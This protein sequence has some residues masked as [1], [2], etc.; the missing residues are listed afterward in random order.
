MISRE[1]ATQLLDSLNEERKILELG[2][3]RKTTTRVA[4]KRMTWR[5]DITNLSEGKPV[6]TALI[7]LELTN[8]EFL[9]FRLPTYMFHRLRYAVASL[10]KDI[11]FL[12]T[13]SIMNR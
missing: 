11:Q 2:F 6:N 1:F 13:K 10:L 3:H 4:I 9:T 5:F 8:N 7:H 12:E